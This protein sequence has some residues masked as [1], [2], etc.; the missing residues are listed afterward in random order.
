MKKVYYTFA[1]IVIV[2]ALIIC[3]ENVASSGVILV[4][5]DQ[6]NSIFLGLILMF[7]LGMIAGFFLGLA[8]NADKTGNAMND[9]DL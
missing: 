8:V 7:I 1:G 2:L 5:L 4:L 6:I 3:F 9:L